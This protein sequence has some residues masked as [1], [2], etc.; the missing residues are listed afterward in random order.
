MSAARPVAELDRLIDRIDAGHAS[1]LDFN[2]TDAEWDAW[3]RAR[4]FDDHVH[5]NALAMP[6]VPRWLAELAGIDEVTRLAIAALI[7]VADPTGRVR[8]PVRLLC[9]RFAFEYRL[10]NDPL[11]HLPELRC[12]MRTALLNALETKLVRGDE[13]AAILMRRLR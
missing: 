8:E 4:N 10:A 13:R 9:A 11:E 5:H 7:E 6:P 12:P 1:P 2:P 3:A